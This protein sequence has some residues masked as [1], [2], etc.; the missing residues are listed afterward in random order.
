MAA[1][2]DPYV[3]V[4]YSIVDDER[5][6]NVYK[7]DRALATWLRLLIS[8][9]ASWP[10]S[11]PIPRWC[12]TVSLQKLVSS[13]LV[14]LATDH[15]RIHGLDRERDGKRQQAAAAGRSRARMGQRDTSGRWM[16]GGSAHQRPSS[17]VPAGVQPLRSAPLNSA[18]LPAG[19]R[20]SERVFEER[21]G[22][23]HIT[24]AIERA[25][26]GITGQSVLQASDKVQTDL[27]R[28]AEFHGEASLVS[29]MRSVANGSRLSWPQVVYGARNAL[30]PIPSKQSKADA[31]EAEK[32]EARKQFGGKA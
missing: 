20:D 22:L 1:Q 16:G 14:E 25:G 28:L 10:A 18:P 6:E 23:P 17:D 27:D 5:F 24:V 13:G 9:D 4:Y 30:E 12:K 21:D 7:D 32:D 26:E 2:R 8:A 31:A 29:A 11:A 3:R 19:A 15:Y